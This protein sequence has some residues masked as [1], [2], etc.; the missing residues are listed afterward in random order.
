MISTSAN[1]GDGLY[2]E[3]GAALLVKKLQAEKTELF[4]SLEQYY[5]LIYKKSIENDESCQDDGELTMSFLGLDDAFEKMT[6]AQLDE[7]FEALDDE[8]FDR[9]NRYNGF[10]TNGYDQEIDAEDEFKD[11]FFDFKD[12]SDDNKDGEE[13]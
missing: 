10:I 1:E 11:P 6:D 13:P 5:E 2:D 7:Y 9:F 3:I 4:E 8:E 12:L